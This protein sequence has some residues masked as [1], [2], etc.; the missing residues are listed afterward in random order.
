MTTTPNKDYDV[1]RG[2]FLSSV[3][4]ICVGYQ[5]KNDAKRLT[6]RRPTRPGGFGPLRASH[7][8]RIDLWG[9]HRKGPP[10][11]VP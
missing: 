9:N 4:D 2:G 8:R 11:T 7:H 6:P 1:A 10:R 3:A 5:L